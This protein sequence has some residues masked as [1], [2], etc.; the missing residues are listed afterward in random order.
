MEKI[1]EE[2]KLIV[3]EKG[4]LA[5][6]D[7]PEMLGD[8]TGS[9]EDCLLVLRPEST[10]EVSR[11]TAVCCANGIAIVPQG[12]NT[13]L[14]RMAI[15][16]EKSPTIVLSLKRMN[17]IIDLNVANAT[18]TVEAGCVMQVLQET[19]AQNGLLFAPD[20][21]ARGAA[22][23]G[24]AVGTNGGGLN[25]LR[26][27]TT[28][29]QVL[30][31]EVVLPDGR[32]WNGLRRLIKDNSGFDL[33][34]LFIGSEGTLGIITKLAFK[35]HPEQAVSQSM[36]VALS[37]VSRLIE[38]YQLGRQIAG[39]R[40]AAFELMPGIG[41]EKALQRYPDIKRPMEARADWY[42]LIRMSDR[43]SVEEHLMSLFE[44]G[45]HREVIADGVLASS[46]TQERNLWELREQMIPHQYFKDYTMLKWDVSVPVDRIADFLLSAQ[47]KVH[48][49]CSDAICYAVS[50]V[51]DGNIHYTA[52]LD[53]EIGKT[54]VKDEIY[55][56]IDELIWSFG[57]SVVAEHG[58][59]ALFRN[60]VK[61]QKSD[62]E[63]DLLTRVKETFDPQGL[64]NPGKMLF[65]RA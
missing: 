17:R 6:E 45:L 14:C 58:V 34:Q 40:L 61:R 38:L 21:G 7:A 57:G 43:G 60:Q 15:P 27:G 28:R 52:Y 59:G 16:T 20:W 62:V 23:V 53:P 55:D 1:I 33:K 8:I 29:E 3:G 49:L 63:Y 64:M 2:L 46:G 47:A 13:N 42:V 51:G 22:T 32:V 4:W 25:V 10:E 48:G 44:Q 39:E 12:G 50:H 9:G 19:A 54:G 5:V 11:I 26:Y 18:V 56:V 31:L 35:L 41:I 30:G 37:D 65:G 24:G 36:M